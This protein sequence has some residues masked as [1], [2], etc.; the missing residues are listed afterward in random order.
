MKNNKIEISSWIYAAAYLIWGVLLSMLVPKFAEILREMKLMSSPLRVIVFSI[1]SVIWLL[2]NCIIAILVILRDIFGKRSLFPDWVAFTILIIPVAFYMFALSTSGGI[3]I[4]AILIFASVMSSLSQSDKQR[5]ATALCN[6]SALSKQGKY[7]EAL[8]QLNKS[9]EKHPKDSL[10]YYLRGCTYFD[11]KDYENAIS[12][13]TKAYEISQ[14][15]SNALLMRGRCYIVK[16]EYD[17]AEGDFA[18]A[19][20]INANAE[21]YNERVLVYIKKGKYDK[22]WEDLHKAESLANYKPNEDLI[23]KLKKESGRER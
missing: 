5:S 21:A 7:D 2:I 17:E 19:I 8:D 23:A 15:Y 10:S 11:K 3:V 9:I 20:K 13:F 22:A 1:P 16:Q 14:T 18:Q 4:G 6:A 12:D